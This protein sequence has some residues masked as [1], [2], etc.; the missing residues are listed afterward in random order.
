MTTPEG[1]YPVSAGPG[2]GLSS[3]YVFGK[4]ISLIGG[5][6][7]DCV[8]LYQKGEGEEAAGPGLETLLICAAA[9]RPTIIK[10]LTFRN[11]NSSSVKTK[12][13]GVGGGHIQIEVINLIK[14]E[15]LSV[16]PNFLL[17]AGL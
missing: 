4:N 1:V 5:S 6:T 17:C 13:F 8:L 2:N 16:C 15:N 10:R 7:K 11:A 9:G 12:F 3:F 14:S